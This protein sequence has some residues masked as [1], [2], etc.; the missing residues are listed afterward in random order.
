M[1]IFLPINHLKWHTWGPNSICCSIFGILCLHVSAMGSWPP[2]EAQSTQ[3][4]PMW[5]DT[6]RFMHCLFIVI[7]SLFGGRGAF[8]RPS[9]ARAMVPTWGWVPKC[10]I[11]GDQWTKKCSFLIIVL[12][13]AFCALKSC[14]LSLLWGFNRLLRPR[15]PES[16]PKGLIPLS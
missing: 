8:W 1:S 5:T 10:A 14:F 4:V 16:S 2:R 15:L 3:N 12:F 9:W 7:F 13:L 11:L 6:P